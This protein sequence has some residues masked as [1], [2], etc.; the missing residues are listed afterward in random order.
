MAPHALKEFAL[1]HVNK[2]QYKL[3]DLLKGIPDLESL[4]C[5]ETEW[6]SERQ[7]VATWMSLVAG[8]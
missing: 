4:S 7:H 8:Y 3:M 1:Q 5:H 6:D 2:S